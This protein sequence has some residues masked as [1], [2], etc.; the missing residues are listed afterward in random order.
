MDNKIREVPAFV[1]TDGKSHLLLED[2]Q[3][4]QAR[5]DLFELLDQSDAGFSRLEIGVFVDAM[6]KNADAFVDALTRLK[7]RPAN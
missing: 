3:A 1:T 2:A 6:A 7:A 4:H 5:L